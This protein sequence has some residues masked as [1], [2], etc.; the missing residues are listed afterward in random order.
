MRASPAPNRRAAEFLGPP[1]NMLTGRQ[2]SGLLST[3]LLNSGPAARISGR[4]SA[5]SFTLRVNGNRSEITINRP[6]SAWF[7]CIAVIG[8]RNSRQPA[9]MAAGPRR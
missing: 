7:C 3:S 5:A 6:N 2:T 9:S 4:P 1:G 8:S